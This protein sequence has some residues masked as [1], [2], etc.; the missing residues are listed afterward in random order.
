MDRRRTP[1]LLF[2]AIAA[3]CAGAPVANP[4]ADESARPVLAAPPA[5]SVEPQDPSAQE[6]KIS[7]TDPQDGQFDLSQFLASRVGFMPVPILITEPAVGYGGG[8]GLM[9]LHD[10]LGAR[11]AEGKFKGTPSISGIFGGYTESDSWFLGGGHFGSWYDDSLR[12]TGLIGTAHPNL[13]FFGTGG[14]AAGTSGQH[15]IPFELDGFGTRQELISR[16]AKTPLFLGLRYEYSQTDTNFDSG[17]PA[18]DNKNLD[19]RD[20]ALAL[21]AQYDT[22]DNILSPNRGVNPRLV[23]SRYDEI[24]GGEANYSRVDLDA[25]GWLPVGETLVAG[26]HGIAA[27]SDSEAPFYALPYVTLR[28]VPALR[29]QGTSALSLEAELRWNFHG[30]WSLVGFGGAGQAVDS[31]SDFGG[32]S[33]TVWA[34]GAGFRYLISRVFGLQ[35]GLDV[36]QGPEETAIYVQIGN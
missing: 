33:D 12:Y 1:A 9:F 36:A 30:R 25:P 8:L 15:S 19:T 26:L 35:A 16:I 14:D 27:F 18:I 2:G 5:E 6:E 3:G 11:D 34:H 28:G 22:R 21:V 23:L 4:V 10:K 24:F 13:E 32:E 7:F 31:N 20:A 17:F 29:Y